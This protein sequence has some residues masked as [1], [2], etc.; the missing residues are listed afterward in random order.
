MA[1]ATATRRAST[2]SW[3]ALLVAGEAILVALGIGIMLDAYGT[4]FADATTAYGV[5]LAAVVVF[6]GESAIFLVSWLGADER[7][8]A[9]AEA[10]RSWWKVPMVIAAEAILVMGAA[11][12]VWDYHASAPASTQPCS[13]W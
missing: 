3:W 11:G 1:T 8:I 9:S 12:V 6:V 4:S 2:V 7:G 10:A 5:M 13:R